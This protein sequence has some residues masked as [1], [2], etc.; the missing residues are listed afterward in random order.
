MTVEHVNCIVCSGEQCTRMP[1]AKVN[2]FECGRCGT[3][4]LSL[5]SEGLLEELLAESPL[6]RSHMSYT[7]RRM[8][9]SNFQPQAIKQ[10]DLPTFWS[11]ERLPALQEQVDNL[12]LWIGDN[13]KTSVDYSTGT[14]SAIAAHIGIPISTEGDNRPLDWLMKEIAVQSLFERV[15]AWDGE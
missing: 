10:T 14:P 4:V 5:P 1:G 7:L 9:R 12:L 8:Q 15:G 3:F 13:Q 11:S 6:R 2:R